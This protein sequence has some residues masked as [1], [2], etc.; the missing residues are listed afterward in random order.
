MDISI[1]SYRDMPIL[2]YLNIKVSTILPISK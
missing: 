2:N 1:D